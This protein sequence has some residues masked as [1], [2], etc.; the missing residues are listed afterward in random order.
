MYRYKNIT[1]CLKHKMIKK[2][3][4]AKGKT[5]NIYNNR[6]REPQKKSVKVFRGSLIY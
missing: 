4:G 6:L 2:E 3:K 5:L 1:E